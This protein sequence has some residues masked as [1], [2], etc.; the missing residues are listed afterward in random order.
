MPVTDIKN[1]NASSS[2]ITLWT[3][4]LKLGRPYIEYTGPGSIPTYSEYK[5]LLES[6]NWLISEPEIRFDLR[7]WGD[8]PVR[9]AIAK[10]WTLILDKHGCGE[11]KSHVY[12]DLTASKL[13]GI[14]RTVFAA[15]NHRNPTVPTVEHRKDL[16]AKHGGLTYNHSKQTPLGNPYQVSTPSGKVPDIKPPC[17]EYNLFHTAQKLQLNAYSGKGSKVC[18]T[19]PFFASGCEYLDERQKTLGS[20][21]IKDDAGNVVAEIPNYPDIRADLNGLNQFDEPTALIVDEIDQ[22]LEAT[23]PLHVGLNT[24]SR[25]MMRLEALKD[26]KLAAVLEWLIRKVYKVV[27]TYEPSSPHGL[28]HQKTVPLLPTKSDVQQIIDEI[29][30]D[31]L[32]NPAVNFWSKIEYTYD[33]E[34]DPVTGELTSVVTG[35]HETFSIPSIDDLITQCQKLLQTK[36]DEIIDAGMTPG[37][38]TEALELNHVLDFLSPILKVINGHKKTSLSL[39]KNCLTIT[40]PWYRHQNIIKSAAI[41]IFLDATIDV[42][43]LRNKLNLDR[44]QPILTFSSKEKDY[45]NLH[46]KFLTDFGHGSNL[47][48]SGSEYCEI[49]RITALINQVSKNHPNEK[50]GLIDHKAHAYSH[51]LPD[52]VVKVGH[53]G[54]DSRGSNQF[55][56]CTVM[57]DIGDYTENLG[58]NAADWHCTTGQSVNPTNLSGRYGRYM[59]RRRI[60]DLE[61]V[62]GRPRATN[63]PDEEITIYLPGKWKEAE[64]SAIA[65]RLPGVNIEKVATYDLC[66]KAAQKG[67]QS[68]RKIIETF[69]DLITREQNVTQDNI[70][71]IVGLSRG[72]VAQICKDLLPT[73]FVRFKKMLVLLWNN[74][75]KTNIPEKALSELPEDV[76]WFVMEW[77]PNFHEY[78]QQGEALEEVAKNIELAIEFHGK[79]ILDYVSVDTIVDLIKL[80]MAPM[81]I[82]FWEELRMQR[83]P[84]PI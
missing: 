11:G 49:E 62:I 46:L 76:G 84:I 33:T 26:R 66:Q 78:V 47:R 59:Q 77:L 67:Q 45:S 10:G 83:E 17:V 53:W 44:N 68:Q 79:Q 23:K 27:D 36:F 4:L 81:P 13:D 54:H 30:R 61:Q 3:S 57:I 82:S 25:G 34:R 65:S 64:I 40:K 18:Q 8:A 60:A 32:V 22:T 48:R 69:W 71:K 9:E 74:L 56:D 38:K 2:A 42:N 70:A 80:F 12:G 43:D 1:Q 75:S 41:S 58:A 35:E 29:Y 28:S 73:S 7:V 72:R 50:I 14:Q 20:E 15:S 52:N 24:L 39:N 31:D 21:K 51:K 6:E 55:L 37:E 16:I 63:R 5:K 19:C